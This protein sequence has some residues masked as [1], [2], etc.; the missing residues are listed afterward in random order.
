M[1]NTLRFNL[2]D[3]KKDIR[4]DD[5]VVIIVD[6]KERIGKSVRAMQI[7]WYMA[8]GNLKLDNVALVP[9]QFKKAVETSQKYEVVI[10]DEAYLGL[11]S[12]DSMRS[13]NRLLKKMLVTCGQKNLVL[14]LV[15][16]SVFDLNKYVVLH[17]C[18]GLIHCFKHKG[19]RGHFSFYNQRKTQQLYIMGKKTYSYYRPDPNFSRRFTNTYVLNEEL[20]RQKKAEALKAFLDS[21]DTEAVGYRKAL[22][23]YAVAYASEISGLPPK[24]LKDRLKCSAETIYKAL[25][26]ARDKNKG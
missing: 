1:D 20:Y 13:Y 8:D 24:E 22:Y 15:L 17:R 2:D 4:K 10:F 3:M 16:P 14:I 23:Y 9:E 21:S 12:E 18:D 5:D 7:G 6:G 25:R 19:Q 26:Y 11:A